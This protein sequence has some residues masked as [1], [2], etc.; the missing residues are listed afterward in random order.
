[1]SRII[2]VDESVIQSIREEFEKALAESKFAN[3]K[4]SFT[5]TLSVVD[6]KAVIVYSEKAWLKQEALVNGFDKEVGWHGFA[7]RGDGDEYYIDDIIVYPQ[8]VTGS[9]VT[10]DQIKY[11]NWLYQRDDE[12]FNAIRMQGHSHVNMAVSPSSVDETLY[13]SI[14]S[15]LG[16]ED[17]YIFVIWNKKGDRTVKI[18]DMA[19]NIFFDTNDCD[20]EIVAEDGGITEFL[21]DAKKKVEVKK[22]TY[23]STYYSSGKTSGKA[24][25]CGNPAKNVAQKDFKNATVWDDYMYDPTSYYGGY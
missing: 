9:T 20:V 1:M 24:G 19:K 15:N 8:E 10:T 5:K 6:R 3:G 12:E 16:D 25:Y 13:E 23:Q 11:Q 14:L 21:E 7:R 2:K 4:F 17:F 22:Y 18:Y